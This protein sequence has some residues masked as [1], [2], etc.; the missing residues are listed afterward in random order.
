M[1]STQLLMSYVNRHSWLHYTVDTPL[2]KLAYPHLVQHTENLT[3]TTEAYT[4]DNYRT[5][6]RYNPDQAKGI[7]PADRHSI[8]AKSFGIDVDDL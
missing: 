8:R 6:P 1:H 4:P 5:N 2:S 3:G 7:L